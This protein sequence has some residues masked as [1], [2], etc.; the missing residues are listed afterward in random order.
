LSEEDH[1]L[2]IV[3]P[4]S[5]F[6]PTGYSHAARMGDLVFVSGET[7]RNRD[8]STHAVGDVRGQTEK[9]FENLERVLEACGSGLDL[10]GKI[11]VYTTKLEYRPI[12]SE[13]R[14]KVFDRFG[15]NCASTTIVITS[16]VSPEWL[17]EIEAVALV[18]VAGR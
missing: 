1:V 17:V 8:G 9:V 11:T 10:V 14:Q 13:V 12:I 4:D 6:V 15:R 5:V 3:N 7:P 2:E 16:L 18:R